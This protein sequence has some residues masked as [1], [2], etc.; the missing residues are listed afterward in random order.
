MEKAIEITLDNCIDPS[1]P[2]T[3]G[4]QQRHKNIPADTPSAYWK[5]AIYLPF[6]DHLVTEVNEKLMVPLPG[7]QAQLL[8]PGK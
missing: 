5:R 7:L 1:S 2:R 4:R 6:Q 8:I 3:A